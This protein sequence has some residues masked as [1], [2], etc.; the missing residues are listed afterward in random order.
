M[1]TDI[2]PSRRLVV[3]LPQD[4]PTG[5]ANIEIIIS[6]EHEVFVFP[7]PQVDIDALPKYRDPKTGELRLVERSGVVRE[8][9]AGQ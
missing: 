8:V 5:P 6:Q 9:V 7:T 3:D 4:I 2:P 1:T